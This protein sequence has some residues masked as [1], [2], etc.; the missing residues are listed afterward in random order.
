[1]GC[2]LGSAPLFLKEGERLSNFI[3]S[4]KK[5][6]YLEKAFDSKDTLHRYYYEN[7]LNSSFKDWGSPVESFNLH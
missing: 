1:M 4:A 7:I 5:S 2:W 3:N 6:N